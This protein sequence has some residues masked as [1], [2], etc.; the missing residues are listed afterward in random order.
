[1]WEI[2]AQ[3][4]IPNTGNTIPIEVDDCLQVDT[5]LHASALVEQ[6]PN[7]DC[8]S[9][10]DSIELGEQPEQDNGGVVEGA[11]D[12]GTSDQEGHGRAQDDKKDHR[13]KPPSIEAA[14]VVHMKIKDILHPKRQTGHGY[15]NPKLDLLLRSQ[16]KA[17]QCF[18]WTYINPESH[19]YNK[20]MAASLDTAQGSGWGVWF[21]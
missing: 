20:W 3:F 15:K 10:H 21:A 13:W 9:H 14:K 11:K 5:D 16:L 1:V 2:A 8:D 18:L 12:P 17:M 6:G 4:F 7:R 19:F